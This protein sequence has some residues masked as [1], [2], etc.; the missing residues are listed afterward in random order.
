MSLILETILEALVQ[1]GLDATCV[2]DS[3]RS[4]GL[5]HLSI[6]HN[7]HAGVTTQKLIING[8]Q[9]SLTHDH[10]VVLICDHGGTPFYENSGPNKLLDLGDPL[11]ATIITASTLKMIARTSFEEM[12]SRLR[13]TNPQVVLK[14]DYRPIS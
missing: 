10:L 6:H 13:T 14:H 3:S 12:L 7:H 11:T 5:L 9:L 4:F 1:D 2:N 8:D